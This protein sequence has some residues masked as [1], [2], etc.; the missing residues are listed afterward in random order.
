MDHKKAVARLKTGKNQWFWAE[1]ESS[2]QFDLV[3]RRS[4]HTSECLV[5]QTSFVYENPELNTTVCVPGVKRKL[6]DIIISQS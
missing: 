5:Q 6:S 3:K 4:I 1:V 2:Y